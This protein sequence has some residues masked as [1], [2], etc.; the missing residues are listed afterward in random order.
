M[1]LLLHGLES[2]AGI[3]LLFAL[4]EDPDL[5]RVHA[6]LVADAIEVRAA[7]EAEAVDLGRGRKH[8]AVEVR[9]PLG[10][11]PE[12][13]VVVLPAADRLLDL[14]GDAVGRLVERG[15]VPEHVDALGP[16]LHR[17]RGVDG[18]QDLVEVLRGLRGVEGVRLD[19]VELVDHVGGVAAVPEVSE[20]PGRHAVEH[21]RRPA[22]AAHVGRQVLE[23]ERRLPAGRDPEVEVNAAHTFTM[24]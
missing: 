11:D 4:V 5:R 18:A 6:Q 7:L 20:V 13:A 24:T 14:V 21:Q 12:G 22:V 16:L 9:R 10:H 15:L 3:N 8:D 2:V 17:R 19:P 1:A 23:G